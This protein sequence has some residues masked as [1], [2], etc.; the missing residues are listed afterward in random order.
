[1]NS[2]WQNNDIPK[3]GLT[4][5]YTVNPFGSSAGRVYRQ[6]GYVVAI[7]LVTMQFMSFS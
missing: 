3:T 5:A 4:I 2:E 1:M 6:K 7:T